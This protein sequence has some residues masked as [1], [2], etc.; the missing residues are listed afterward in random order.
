MAVYTNKKL[1]ELQKPQEIWIASARDSWPSWHLA[2]NSKTT[3]WI[4]LHRL[5]PPD[6]GRQSSI[7]PS[8][9]FSNAVVSLAWTPCLLIQLACHTE[10]R[11]TWVRL[12]EP[13]LWNHSA[14]GSS[15]SYRAAQCHITSSY[16]VGVVSSHL[17]TGAGGGV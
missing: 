9:S 16:H 17:I 5:S 14:C 6:V 12:S 4:Y 11:W 15:S 10:S 8:A 1:F 7:F 13:L 3:S 2:C